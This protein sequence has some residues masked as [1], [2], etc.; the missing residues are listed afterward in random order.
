[1]TT[2]ANTPTG[3]TV[4]VPWA[5]TMS[6]DTL[7]TSLSVDSTTAVALQ[8]AVDTQRFWATPL[9]AAS[10]S[11]YD[12]MQVTLT[13]PRLVNQL[14]F[15]VAI[16]PQTITV[17]YYNDAAA[18][19]Q[20]LLQ[21]GSTSAVSVTQTISTSY[22]L[23]LP[24]I[25]NV[26]GHVHPQH[27]FSG[28]WQTIEF[29][30][31]PVTARL[32]RV[33]L[34]RSTNGVAPTDV[35]GNPVPYSLAIRH[36]Y[37]GYVVQ[38][39]TDVPLS[40]PVNSALTGDGSFASTIDLLGSTVNFTMQTN[41]AENVLRN[42]ATQSNV[43]WKCAPQPFPWAV[44]GFYVDARDVNGNAQVIDRF[45]LEP[46][47]TGP[48]VH[49]YYSNDTVT[50]AYAGTIEP[51]I[52][53]EAQTFDPNGVGGDVL[54]SGSAGTGATAF[55]KVDNQV[56]SFDPS[57]SWWVGARVNDKTGH[58]T[59]NYDSPLFD[60][61]AF[62]IFLTPFG[63]AC[64]TVYGDTLAIDLDPFDPATTLTWMVAYD[65]VDT[66]SINAQ[67]GPVTYTG[68]MPLP[69]PLSGATVTMLSIGAFLGA[70]PGVNNFDFQDFV[71]KT[72]DVP[73]AATIQ[74]FLTHPDAYVQVAAF[75]SQ[76]DPRT[77]NALLRYHPGWV[78]N[79]V[80]SG[81]IGGEPNQYDELVWSPIARDYTLTKGNFDVPATKAKYW[82]FEF[83]SLIPEPYE[84]YK[85]ITSVVRTFSSTMTG[86]SSTTNNFPITPQTPQGVQLQATYQVNNALTS[87]FDRVFTQTGT[88]AAALGL[89]P[90]QARVLVDNNSRVLVGKAYW[91]WNFLPVHSSPVVTSFVGTTK[92]VYETINVTQTSKIAYFVGLV[93]IAAYRL[94][95][96]ATDDTIRYVD[97]FYDLANIAQDTNWTLVA[98]HQLT[99]GASQYAVLQSQPLNSTRIVTAVQFAAQQSDPIQ[100]LPD[101]DFSDPTHVNWAAVGDANLAP[102]ITVDTTVG[103]T[104]Q[105]SRASVPNN[106][107]IIET[108][109]PAWHNITD[110]NLSWS[111]LATSAQNTALE[112]GITSGAIT[113]PAG[114]RITAAARVITATDLTSPLVVQIVNDQNNQVVSESQADVTAHQVTEWYTSFTLG[115]VAVAP[116]RWS[117][118]VSAPVAQLFVDGF[119]HPSGRPLP[120]MDSGQAWSSD[121]GNQ[122]Q[123]LSLS[124]VNNAAQVTTDGQYNYVDVRQPWGT[125]EFQA[126]TIGNSETLL[127]LIVNPIFFSTTTG[128]TATDNPT[129]T[130]GQ[131]AGLDG[132]TS[133]L[134]ITSTDATVHT[135]IAQTAMILNITPNF[136]YRWAVDLTGSIPGNVVTMSVQ[137]YNSS[138]TLISTSSSN[139]TITSGWNHF[140]VF[141]TAPT[142]AVKAIPLLDFG[143]MAIGSTV[144][145]TNAYFQVGSTSSSIDLIP[146]SSFEVNTTGW[147]GIGSPTITRVSGGSPQGGSF[148]AQVK[149][150]QATTPTFFLLSTNIPS[151]QPG[152]TYDFAVDVNPSGITAISLQVNWYDSSGTNLL[153]QVASTFSG[154]VTGWQT[155]T[156]HFLAPTNAAYALAIVGGGVM[157]INS[158]FNV[159]NVFFGVPTH[160]ALVIFDPFM[161]DELGV[162]DDNG[163]TPLP[164]AYDT[165]VL[166]SSNTSRFVQPNDDIRV[167]ILPTYLVPGNRQDIAH[168]SNPDPVV[169]PYS[170][171]FFL[172]GT[173]MRTVSHDLG[174]RSLREIKGRLGQRFLSWSWTPFKYSQLLSNVIMYLPRLDKGQWIDSISQ[175]TFQSVTGTTWKATGSWDLATPAERIY[176]DN[177]GPPL[178]VVTSGSTL[179]TD[180]GVWY[181]AMTAY[182]RNI[183]TGV[184]GGPHGDVLVLD[185]DNGVTLNY[186]GNIMRSGTSYGNLIP[187][188]VPTN[189]MVTVQWVRTSVVTAATRGT[190]NATTFPDMIIGKVNGQIVGTFASAQLATWRG[191]KR[192][193]SGDIYNP[194]GGSRP[195]NLPNYLLDTSF[196]SF[197]WAPD[198]SLVSQD[199]TK[200]TWN[201]ITNYNSITYTQVIRGRVLTFPALRA[202]VVQYG[203][204]HDVW[205][206]DNLSLF[207]DP[208]VWSFSN[209]GGTTFFPAYDIRNNPSGVLSFPTSTVVTSLGRTPGTTLTWRA[210][211]YAP[212]RIISS[213]VIRPWYAGLISG[214]THRVGVG[215]TGPNLS[216]NDQTPPLSQDPAFQVWDS[217][218]PQ[219]WWY[220]F[221]LVQRAK[222]S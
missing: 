50:S 37:L 56:L 32:F 150:T 167:D 189:A 194:G 71:L 195:T 95:A 53:P 211:S 148:S 153:S 217:P 222:T 64:R 218:V 42:Q 77:Q 214:A 121:L 84:V 109:Y 114:G 20:P 91:A 70:V 164:A 165:N 139:I 113:L 15:D 188:G 220:Q 169:W 98:D 200:P 104:I 63:M 57:R 45:Y 82:K 4:A 192:G 12:V 178:T 183:A 215:T 34:I 193:V 137:W 86:V 65:G 21:Q 72:D 142:G 16:F 146:N 5:D 22:P 60:C 116:W 99:S 172:N 13:S 202:Q 6:L 78:T 44:V 107:S 145:F 110:L 180:V 203:Q 43:V 112:G 130:L 75:A 198:A 155:L 35:F 126:G 156:V 94:D 207:V 93:S 170:L 210:T 79:D 18:A 59:E 105:I 132:Q 118:F 46:L 209:D 177:Y 62:R 131:N 147:V 216:V 197:H 173:W 7:N 176:A 141:L 36:F 205:D 81:F 83:S 2:P 10:D 149:S 119:H 134:Q 182:V 196:R 212:D 103:N 8:Q 97:N 31:Q 187:G 135:T 122:G 54:H 85:P 221:K 29:N 55:V 23:V 74:D 68:S 168:S 143:V 138:N 9:R 136:T 208:V 61:G 14:I 17:E 171:M 213:I 39:L 92:H 174:A 106:W 219:S 151:I 51:L 40:S 25:T 26:T 24:P 117:D 181:G 161:I 66:L 185:A 30:T 47:Y 199:P 120:A 115:D 204:S 190:I 41:A 90:T 69:V 175:T 27:S 87:G 191:T 129:L 88:G 166:T 111:R 76:T 201:D 101:S 159:D 49:I 179:T 1:M 133:Y 157:P 19:W 11:T 186:A 184:T 163:G 123:S 96:L 3:S 100:Y 124:I 80:P 28:H 127:N 206:L 125:L 102:G 154:L 158:T 128:W 67:A 108:G 73:N 52:Y 89:T 33:L 144:S 152:I 58:H 162:L 140:D 38:A 160:N 48:S